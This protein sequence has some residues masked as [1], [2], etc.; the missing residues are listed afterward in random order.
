[1]VITLKCIEILKHYI[2]LWVNYT[3]KTKQNENRL[4]DTENKQVVSRGETGGGL[5]YVKGI[6]R[7]NPP[8]MK[9]ATGT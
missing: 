5:K 7:Y 4:T 8:V 2:V 1:M 3:S 9:Q 6:K